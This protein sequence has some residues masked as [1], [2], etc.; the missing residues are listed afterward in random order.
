MQYY[1]KGGKHM[2]RRKSARKGRVGQEP[3]SLTPEQRSEI[4]KKAAL[5]RWSGKT[6]QEIK[7][8]VLKKWQ[9]EIPCERW[10]G[11]REARCYEA[12]LWRAL[13]MYRARI[14][15]RKKRCGGRCTTHI[16]CP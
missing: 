6:P 13:V 8:G 12:N 1:L 2:E 4:A 3:A 11:G 15:G 9:T 10:I 5:K 16:S 7:E 14:V